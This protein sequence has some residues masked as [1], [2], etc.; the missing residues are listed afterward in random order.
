MAPTAGITYLVYINSSCKSVIASGRMI[1]ALVVALA[2]A[3]TAFK[4]LKC[5]KLKYLYITS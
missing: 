2:D 5:C 4:A 3:A 1:V